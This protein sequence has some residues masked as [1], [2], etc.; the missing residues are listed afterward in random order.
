MSMYPEPSIHKKFSM[1]THVVCSLDKQHVGVIAGVSHVHIFWTYIIM[2][3][4]PY[5]DPEL[6]MIYAITCPGQLITEL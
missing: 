6:G 2:L 4:R 5:S 3:D 1:G